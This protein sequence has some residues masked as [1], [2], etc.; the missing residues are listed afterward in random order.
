VNE[1][2]KA[3]TKPTAEAMRAAITTPGVSMG[4][5]DRRGALASTRPASGTESRCCAPVWGCSLRV[6]SSW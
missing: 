2:V 1:V 6:A 4:A 3:A 5:M